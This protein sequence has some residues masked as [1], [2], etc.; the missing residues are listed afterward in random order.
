MTDAVTNRPDEIILDGIR[1]PLVGQL[2]RQPT[3]SFAE[4]QVIGQYTNDSMK[5]LDTQ[6]VTSYPGYVGI[7]EAITNVERAG[8]RCWWTDCTMDNDGYLS[9]PRLAAAI[10]TFTGQTGGSDVSTTSYYDPDSRWSSET[11]TGGTSPVLV[12]G[13]AWDSYCYWYAPPTYCNAVHLTF[14]SAIA[15][16]DQAQVDIL[17]GDGTYTSIYNGAYTA[18]AK[19]LTFTAQTC[20]GVRVRFQD[21]AGVA[22]VIVSL[23]HLVTATLAVSGS[24]AAM[25]DF[26]SNQYVAVGVFLMKLAT[27]RASYTT[28]SILPA[29]ITALIPSLN[30]KL[31]IYL[32]DTFYYCSMNTSEVVATSTT[33][34][35]YYGVQ[36]D[37]KLWKMNSSG[38]MEYSVDPDAAAP[39]W[40]GAGDITDIASQIER[41]FL[42]YDSDGNSAMYC[43][44][45]SNLK[46]Y[47]ST[48]AIWLD[49]EVRLPNHPNGGKGAV[50]WNGGHYISYGLGVKAY[51]PIEYTCSDVGLN[52]DD[53]IPKEYN[54]EIVAFNPDSSS[55]ALFA[56]VD[57]TQG[58]S[59]LP[60]SYS[61]L[62]SF[63]GRGWKFWW[64]AVGTED[65]MHSVITS[66]ASSAYAVYWDS[67]GIVY[68][69]D[70]IRGIN[71]PRQLYSRTVDAYYVTGDDDQIYPSSTQY[72]YQTFTPASSHTIAGVRIK[73]NATMSFPLLL[74]GYG[75]ISGLGSYSLSGTAVVEVRAT[76]GGGKPTGAALATAT[77]DVG[78]LQWGNQWVTVMFASGG[79]ALTASTKYAFVFYL[80]TS[81]NT[82]GWRTD[83]TSPSYAG[84]NAGYSTD[85]GSTWTAYSYDCM[86]EEFSYTGYQY[87]AT[88]GTYL[89]PWFDGNWT[90]GKKLAVAARC[91]IRG[92]VSADET[93]TVYYRTNHASDDLTSG[94][95]TLGSAITSTGETR[96]PFPNSTTPDGV[97]FDSIQFKIALA[98]AAGTTTETPVVV[99]LM[100]DYYKVIPKSWGWQA[101][102]NLTKMPAYH[103]KSPEQLIEALIIAS[104]TESLLSFIWCDTTKYV[105]VEDITIDID[106]GDKPKGTAK[107]FLTEA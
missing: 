89:T 14:A 76:D 59:S 47:D 12:A 36:W 9:L 83:A 86:F 65:A 104:E 32:G 13:G 98:R 82:L 63:D 21:N 87:Y 18:G 67:D 60:A 35:A 61:G 26:N 102:L 23:I 42:G 20:Y 99:Y 97:I 41:M 40:T 38:T 11:T 8:G 44:T 88:S 4:K 51:F 19:T 106:T 101:T 6:Q 91:N 29:N 56:L 52:L 72:L 74:F 48:N 70:L 49:T 39:T 1:Y 22:Q 71:A 46:I 37:G 55:G 17:D 34:N 66:S 50:Y 92:D 7:E 62:W 80:G 78:A 96:L 3:S 93:V 107:I 69:I 45:N 95:I 24:H 100:I 105:R 16:C 28:I 31:Y 90:A 75:G 27:N 43:A 94:W 73:L 57:S 84:G 58:S 54:G 5:R 81:T 103:D 33:A 10:S 79:V 85:S 68:Y 25:V 53:G 64:S 77:I 2:R 30:S 15:G